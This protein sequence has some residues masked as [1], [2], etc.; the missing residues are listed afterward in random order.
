MIY[1]G[2]GSGSP[3][4]TEIQGHFAALAQGESLSGVLRV[5]HCMVLAVARG[6]ALNYKYEAASGLNLTTESP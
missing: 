2:G 6:M 1:T 5:T 3:W 4:S